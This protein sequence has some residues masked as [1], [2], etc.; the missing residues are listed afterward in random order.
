MS[1][2]GESQ[3]GEKLMDEFCLLKRS[4]YVFDKVKNEVNRRHKLNK[5][6]KQS[7]SR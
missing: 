4:S 5:K 3:N 1:V 2:Q 7:F 6:K